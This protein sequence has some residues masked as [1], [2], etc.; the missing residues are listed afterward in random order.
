MLQKMTVSVFEHLGI[1]TWR[2]I[3]QVWM[4]VEKVLKGTALT[5]FRNSVL[6]CKELV[7]NEYG[8]QWGLGE[9]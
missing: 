3:D 6:T 4:Y 2:G 8:D 7:R 9:T 5:K 1:T